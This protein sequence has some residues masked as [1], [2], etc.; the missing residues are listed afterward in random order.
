MTS[1]QLN[2]RH[3]QRVSAEDETARTFL[4]NIEH[5]DAQLDE[6]GLTMTQ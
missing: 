3:K 6:M 2:H 5:L 4:D 1:P